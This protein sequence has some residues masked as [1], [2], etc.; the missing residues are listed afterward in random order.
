MWQ[1]STDTFLALMNWWRTVVLPR[2]PLIEAGWTW[3]LE[4][5]WLI[6]WI[7]STETLRIVLRSSKCTMFQ[8]WEWMTSWYNFCFFFLYIIPHLVGGVGNASWNRLLSS[9][10]PAVCSTLAVCLGDKHVSEIASL[11]LDLVAGFVVLQVPHR[12]SLKLNVRMGFH[13]WILSWPA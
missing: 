12:P 2:W 9:W 5:S 8:Q 1:Y 10:S 7:C 6:S 4:F 3:Y 13:R 11:A